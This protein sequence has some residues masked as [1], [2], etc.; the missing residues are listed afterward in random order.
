MR[1]FLL[2]L[3]EETYA[4]QMSAVREVVPRPP[5]TLL[6]TAPPSVLGLFNVRGEILPLLDTASLLDLGS[7][8]STTYAVVVETP[9]GPAGLAASGL[10]SVA[11]LGESMPAGETPAAIG[12]YA[13][14]GGLAVLLDIGVLLST[15][16]I[17][18]WPT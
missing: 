14:N 9:D 7:L 12:T 1:A 10:P 3:G 2:P 18:G 17:R 16:R 15:E 6:P 8:D 5:L 4:L 13:V 11:E